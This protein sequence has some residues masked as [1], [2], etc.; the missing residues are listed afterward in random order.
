MLAIFEPKTTQEALDYAFTYI[1][2]AFFD[3]PDLASE[4]RIF[5]IVFTRLEFKFQQQSKE[6]LDKTLKSWQESQMSD[7]RFNYS[8][9][10]EKTF[11][12]I[13]RSEQFK[14]VIKD[15]ENK[16]LDVTFLEDS[17][18]E[19]QFCDDICRY[20]IKMEE[21]FEFVWKNE[22]GNACKENGIHDELLRLLD[23]VFERS[24]KNQLFLKYHE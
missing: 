17:E 7:L 19:A 18:S 11:R 6:L 21:H 13:C 1:E 23:Q 14:Q 12:E 5:E 22:I 9:A 20:L 4:E 24:F 3:L 8:Y 10:F 15:T 16:A 2:N